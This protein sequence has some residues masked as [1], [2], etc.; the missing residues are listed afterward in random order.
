MSS[1]ARSPKSDKRTVSKEE[2]PGGG[3]AMAVKMKLLFKIRYLGM[4]RRRW[5]SSGYYRRPKG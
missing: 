5:K 2:E 1:G 4:A 3:D